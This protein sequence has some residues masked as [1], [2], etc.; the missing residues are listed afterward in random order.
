MN[1]S[2]DYHGF[3]LSSVCWGY[4]DIFRKTINRLHDQGY[5]GPE[6]PEITG[7]F[8][9]LMRCS[10]KTLFDH[11]LKSF[12]EA[13]G[14]KISWILDIPAVFEEVIRIGCDLADSKIHYGIYFFRALGEGELGETPKEL[15]RLLEWTTRLRKIDD[16]LAYALLKGYDRLR[17]RL[18][19]R[20]LDSYIQASISIYRDNART[21]IRYLECSLAG[22]EETLR[23]YTRECVLDDIHESL[24]RL[25]FA[26]SKSDVE[27]A[28]LA[29]LDSD[30]LIMRGTTMVT[31]PHNIYL[32][33]R[34]REFETTSHNHA[35]YLLQAIVSAGMLSCRS[36]PVVHGYQG[37]ENLQAIAGE[38][39][40]LLNVLAVTE[41]ARSIRYVNREWPGARDL[42]RWGFYHEQAPG[43]QSPEV[44]LYDLFENRCRVDEIEQICEESPNVLG[45]LDMLSPSILAS[46]AESYPGI[47]IQLLRAFAFLPDFFYETEYSTPPNDRVVADL[48]QEAKK[49]RS[50][51]KKSSSVTAKDNENEENDT[52]SGAT[53]NDEE[54]TTAETPEPA[55]LYDEW[56]Q[57]EGA[58]YRD[59]CQVRE[60]T[61]KNTTG[62]NASARP[63]GYDAE[64]VRRVFELIRP[65]A[66]HREKRLEEGDT[67]NYDRLIEY[68]VDKTHDPSPKVR[69]YE[70][71]LIKRRDLS[72]LILI[73]VSGSTG[74]SVGDHTVLLL[75]KQAAAT[76]GEGLSVLDDQFALCG[77]SGNGRDDCRFIIYK[78]F[79]E[80]WSRSVIRR[81]SSARSLQSTRIGAA[82]RHAGTRLSKRSSKQRLIMLITDG[83]PMDRDYD[84]ETR[85][86][87]HDV[88]MACEENRRKGIYTFCISTLENSRPDME[89]MFPERRFAILYDIRELPR[90]L[91][92]LYLRLTT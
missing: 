41:I 67:I 58:Y 32:P 28:S 49:K 62:N 16:E 79:D 85:Y 72:V 61:P 64:K 39:R 48:H 11:V 69:F 90:V 44:L 53:D 5:L 9:E 52:G 18:R 70:R 7:R 45:T 50:D 65:A 57:I 81:L 55:Y 37:Y 27:V 60:S 26:L 71:P 1:K 68:L 20:E 3:S 14:P 6:R 46:V 2:I 17:S 22:N 88:R 74:D 51:D 15:N 76:L 63:M 86:A 31:L 66:V 38:N 10:D 83:R 34:I 75:E 4:R 47:D 54:R 12:L 89:I 92:R 59:Y 33:E 42:V 82:L 77:F 91:P 56:N 29:N 43:P 23:A 24:E 73:D 25:V 36:F 35:W 30:E 40:R 19:P 8:F 13:F 84:P 21:G 80:T 87:Q 78:N